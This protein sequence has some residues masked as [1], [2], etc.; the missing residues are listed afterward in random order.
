VVEADTKT[1]AAVELACAMGVVGVGICLVEQL[2]RAGGR[3]LAEACAV[4]AGAWVEAAGIASGGGAVEKFLDPEEH[5]CP[6][7]LEACAVQL[8][9][10]ST[11]TPQQNYENAPEV[12]SGRLFCS[13][14]MLGTMH[15]HT[16]DAQ[17][18][19]L[20]LDPGG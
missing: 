3:T 18:A 20:L 15:T 9:F 7:L 1:V 11:V 12:H 16:A 13:V 10:C 8:T 4:A 5:H 14:I 19:V 6:Q 17:Q 2:T